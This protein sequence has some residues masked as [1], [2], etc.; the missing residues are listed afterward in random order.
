MQCCIIYTK[1]QK[2]KKAKAD[3]LIFKDKLEQDIEVM[4][5]DNKPKFLKK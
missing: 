5:L 3:N 1:M 2:I 4:G